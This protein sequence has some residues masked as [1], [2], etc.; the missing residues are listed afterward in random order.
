LKLGKPDVRIL[1]AF[2]LRQTTTPKLATT[3]VVEGNVSHCDTGGFDGG[4]R[5][6]GKDRDD[7]HSQQDGV[8]I[9]S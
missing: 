2:M 1:R 8:F 6:K 9:S 3:A 5:E 7:A 4:S